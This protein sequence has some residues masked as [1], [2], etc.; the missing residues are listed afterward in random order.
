MK[1]TLLLFLL[2]TGFSAWAS[3]ATSAGRA[4]ENT[5][6]AFPGIVFRKEAAPGEKYIYKTPDGQPLEMEI[7][8]P[9]GHDP[10]TSSVPGVILF[11]GGSWIGGSL[12]QFRSLCAYLASRGMVS[13]TARYRFYKGEKLPV[14]AMI[15]RICI[16]D[17]KSAI[18]WFK[19]NAKDLG[20]DPNRI[21]SGGGSAGAHI[22]T[23]ATLNPGLNDPADP[24]EIDTS[25]IA[26]LWF[27]PAF[28]PGDSKDPEVDALQ[29][30]KPQMPPS[31]VFFG[32]KDDYKKGWDTVHEKIRSLGPDTAE[33]LIA[34]GQ[35]HSFFN[36]VPWMTTCA[37]AID[38]FLTKLGLLKGEPTLNLPASGQRL[39]PANP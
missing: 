36:A 9:P 32:D 18:R 23:L 10:K 19:Q 22:S 15:K 14:A 37:I 8:F 13:A 24:Q 4:G 20:V 31:I 21:I 1:T 27:N 39:V 38:E 33:L 5:P 17:A 35:G 29:H 25:A 34:P 28:S 16:T 3:E 12:D 2:I 7:Y 30:I 26:Y 11:H 6:P